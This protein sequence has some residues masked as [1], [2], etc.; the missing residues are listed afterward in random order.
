MQSKRRNTDH[1]GGLPY[2]INLQMTEQML[3]MLVVLRY[4][5]SL[6]FGLSFLPTVVELDPRAI[7]T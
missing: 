2:E 1:I 6:L 3:A 7:H 5:L 4:H